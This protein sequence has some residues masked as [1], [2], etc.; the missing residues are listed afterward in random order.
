MQ[1]LADKYVVGAHAVNFLNVLKS[2]H[3]TFGDSECWCLR[4]AKNRQATKGFT[5]TQNARP[6]YMGVDARELLL[7]TIDQYPSE[8]K[9]II[10]RR[11][12]CSSTYCINPN[13]YFYGT[14]QDAMEQHN[15]RRGNPVDSALINQIRDSCGRQGKS[16]A[17]IAREYNLPYYTVRRICNHETFSK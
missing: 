6:K 12:C 14:R 17:A 2:F 13:H 7:A 3:T 5:T 4:K 11:G 1:F 15:V 8:S 9:P 16:Y 10:V